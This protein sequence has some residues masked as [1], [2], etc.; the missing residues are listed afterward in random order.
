MNEQNAA[1]LKYYMTLIDSLIANNITPMIT[2]FHWDLPQYLQDI[3]GWTNPV[4][5][6]QFYVYADALYFFY[7]SKVC[8]L[9]YSYNYQ[10]TFAC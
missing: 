6:D 4:M 10:N 9:T 8:T 2:M 5:A 3:G 1:G 7:G